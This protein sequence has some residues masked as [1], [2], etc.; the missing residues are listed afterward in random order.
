MRGSRRCLVIDPRK[1]SR[2]IP[3]YKLGPFDPLRQ[4]RGWILA[5]DPRR[6]VE[7]FEENGAVRFVVPSEHEPDVAYD[8]F[9]GVNGKLIC[10]PCDDFASNHRPCKHIFEVIYRYDLD[11]APPLPLDL[12]KK[13]LKDVPA[14]KPHYAD[15]RRF[16][17]VPFSYQEGFAE[18]TR[19]DHAYE[20][21]DERVLGLLIDLSRKLD[22]R[23]PRNS[24]GRPSLSPGQKALIIVRRTHERKSMRDFRGQLK[25]LQKDG[26]INFAPR[27]TAMVDYQT[28][29]ETIDLLLE[30]FDIV[31]RPY[32]LMESHVIGDTSGFS[33]F[34]IANW[35]DSKYGTENYRPGT[36]WY[37]E[38][39]LIGRIS[40]AILGFL[41][42]PHRGEG[43][44][45]SSNLIPMLR[46]LRS[47]DFDLVDTVIA[48]NTYLIGDKFADVTSMGMRLV[49]PLKPRNFGKDEK[50][51]KGMIDLARFA[52]E[53]P[54]IYDDLVRARNAVEGVFWSQKRD[55][56]HIAA[57]GTQAERAEHAALLVAASQAESKE[58]QEH[59]ADAA[60]ASGLYK[61]R[62][63]GFI[64][65]VLVQ[66]LKRTVTMEHRFNRRISYCNDSVFS[67]V[68]EYSPEPG[69]DAA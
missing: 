45:D 16:P 38:H 50:P 3:A 51:R 15:A 5:Q 63:V 43:T 17:H 58:G 37:K 33:P 49:G 11:N 8:M 65:R 20:D 19:D 48:D 40:K 35:L 21:Q 31:T 60:A 29:A 46:D 18:S 68:R 6:R 69:H 62:I 47:R 34:Y 54:D 66:V 52:D 9:V 13:I 44:G 32:R 1:P 56:N 59:W 57:I 53:H 61:S 26:I 10:T 36:E 42:T 67:H 41:I 23:H 24:V 14:D 22:L 2:Q 64:S 12:L 28:D 4:I 7:R 25:R 27:R 39:V 30:A 55:D